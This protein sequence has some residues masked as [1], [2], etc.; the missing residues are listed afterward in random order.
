MV[1]IV[2]K[3][4]EAAARLNLQLMQA[5]KMASIGE[6]S[7]GVAHEINNPVAIIMTE[8]Q[9]LLDQFQNT[10][11][12]DEAFKEQFLASME[13]IAVQSQRCKRITQNLLRFSRR[14]RSMIEA[15]DLNRFVEEV[16]DLMDREARSS[17]IRFLT[18]LDEALPPIESDASQL[19]QVFLNLM[20]NAIDA[21]EGKP[22]GS[23]RISTKYD[24]A[25]K[26]VFIT[27]ADTGSGIAKKDLDRIFDPFF[28]T[29]PV[30]KGT[31][32]GLSIC[33]SSAAISR[34]EARLGKEPSS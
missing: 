23:I 12:E 22:Y 5:G 34:S 7:A 29:K 32:L 2:K 11:I 1:K 6:L 20:T 30:G 19:Q 26:G 27:I 9:I 28:T 18:E 31:G 16:I 24:E 14:T 8:R 15:V 3:R 4:D 10:A 21:H 13:Q 17:G 33:Y 25:A